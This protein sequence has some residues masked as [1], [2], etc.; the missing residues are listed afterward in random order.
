MVVMMIAI[1]MESNGFQLADTISRTRSF[2][3]LAAGG[4]SPVTI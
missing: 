3:M 2:V 4:S 1:V